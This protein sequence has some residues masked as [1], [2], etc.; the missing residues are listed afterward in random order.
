[1]SISSL[2]RPARAKGALRALA[3]SACVVATLSVSAPASAALVQ[4]SFANGSLNVTINRPGQSGQSTS[5]GGFTG[6]YNGAAF[7]SYCIELAQNFTFGTSYNNYSLVPVASGPNTSPMGP[8]KAMDLAKLV[9][10]NF[11]DSFSSTVKSVAM[12]LA[13]W[14]IVHETSGAYGITSGTFN[15]NAG[16]ANV[17]AAR[18]QADTWLAELPGLTTLAP[19]IALVSPTRQDFITVV[20]VPPS[21]VLFAGGLL[22]GLWG[23][24]RRRTA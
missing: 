5:A 2:L 19:M 4:T 1:M 12:Q 7:L 16:N 3:L 23:V 21:I 18:I 20:P 6:V 10:E 9:A 17:N 13:V 15:V 8:T 22:F 24:R 14:E 11:S